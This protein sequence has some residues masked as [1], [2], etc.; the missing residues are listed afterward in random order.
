MSDIWAVIPVKEFEGAKHRL[1]PLL[2][3]GQR[4]LLAETMLADVL[5]A[6]AGAKSLA[7]V[8]LIT[9]E[10]IARAM[11]GRIGAR[12]EAEGARAGHT[13]SVAAGLRILAREGK[14]G[15]M[16]MPGDIPAVRA[17]EIDAI[18]AAHR[19]AP[20]FTISPAH[21][22]LGSNAVVCSPPDSVPLRFGEN[23]YFPHLDA[24]RAQGIEPTI[25]RQPGVA[26]DIDH[27][28]DLDTF[29]RLPQSHGTRTRILLG[30]FGIAQRPAGAR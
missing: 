16:T 9:L 7:G 6:V 11:A 28:V 18:L 5:E 3:P 14:G 26:M 13:G 30:R 8:M 29:L 23:S 15:F 2:T 19:P 10:P 25:L 4:R 27:P 22:D 1:S 20:S 17:A 21:D 12:V 24:A